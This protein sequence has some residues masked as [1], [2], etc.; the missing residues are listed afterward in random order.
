[1]QEA[2]LRID[3]TEDIFHL[4]SRTR[5]RSR[6]EMHRM[7]RSAPALFVAI[8][9]AAC[10]KGKSTDN[11]RPGATVCSSALDCAGNQLCVNSSCVPTCH[12]TAECATGLVCDEAVCLSPACGN[13]VQCGAP[14]SGQVCTN[15]ACATAPAASQLASCLITPAPAVVRAGAANGIQLKV[16]AQDSAGK[17]LRFTNF[18]WAA[19]GHG[20]VDQYGVVTGTDAGDISVTATVTGSTKSCT[21]TVH[22]YGTPVAGA[23]RVT[24]INIHTKEPINGAKV[25]LGSGPSVTAPLLTGP[26]GTVTFP[27]QTGVTSVHVFASDYSYASYIDTPSKDLLVPLSPVVR[28]SQ[29]SGFTGHVCE[30]RQA[31]PSCPPEGDFAPLNTQGEGVHLAFFGSGVSN[32]LLDLSLDTL[33]GPPHSVTVSLGQS[34]KPVNLPW[35]MV[36]GVGSN[37][38]GTQDYRVFADGGVRALWGMGGN[39]SVSTVN[40]ILGPALQG[41]AATVD[42]GMLLPQLLPLLARTQAGTVIGV[43]APANASPPIFSSASIPLATPMRVRVTA[44][45]PDLPQLDGSYLDGV[46]AVA[47]AMDYPIG[48]VPLGMTAGLS[49]KDSA[50]H[51]TAKIADSNCTDAPAVCANKLLLKMAPENGGTEG[52]KIGVALL[53]LNFGGAAPGASRVAVSGLI[54]VV[55]QLDYVASATGTAMLF[56]DRAFLALPA[57]NSIAVQKISRQMII[58]NDADVH[59]PPTIYR[60]DLENHARLN[61]NIWMSPVGSDAAHIVQLPDPSTVDSSLVDPFQDAMGDDGKTLGPQARLLALQLTGA[62]TPAGLET[63]SNLTL[64]N[65]GTSLAAFTVL[66]VPVQ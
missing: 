10:G 28:S 37:F 44:A 2:G 49:V 24:V 58:N 38:F 9:L 22:S 8:L 65:L 48:F 7:I 35:G 20:A 15:G 66:Q 34:S 64:D 50:G 57:A 23:L 45:T 62:Q 47:G 55:D 43:R 25:V 6:K 1:M 19:T 54:K 41:G 13:D 27:N 18:S 21:S 4:L 60:F 56:T 16:L 36:L 17:P 29:R 42:M 53:A 11:G 32:S 39:L 3:C 30:S 46:W 5:K 26:D 31:E 52:S 33:L 12:S 40:Q 59:H 51:N 63:F 14:S 61:W